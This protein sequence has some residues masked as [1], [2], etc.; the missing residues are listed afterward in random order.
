MSARSHL[1]ELVVEPGRHVHSQKDLAPRMRDALSEVEGAEPM[2]KVVGMVYDRSEILSRHIELSFEELDRRLD[3]YLAVNEATRRL[4]ARALGRLFAGGLSPADC[5]AMVVVTSSHSGFPSLSRLLQQEAG[6]RLDALCYDL[7]GLGCAGPTHGL[8]L[9]S[10]LLE[11]ASVRNV[12]LLCVDVMATH[13]EARRH[14]RA[15][16]MEQLVAHCLASDGAAALVLSKDPGSRSLLSFGSCSLESVLWEDALD[17][18]FF[19]ASDDNQPYLAVGKDIRTRLLQETEA[20]FRQRTPDEP[21]LM[22]PGG[23]AL[24]ARLE[25]AEPGLAPSIGISRSIL[26]EHGNLGAPSLLWVWERAL[27]SGMKMS[28]ALTLFAL[29]PG[30]VTTAIRLEEVH[31]TSEQAVA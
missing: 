14:T 2:K 20:F 12:C 26:S 25:R 15:P 1:L 24:M 7:T 23:A 11:Q 21:F 18:N 22:H 31:Q 28:P 29:G 30:I 13:G 3:W 17:Q 19:S 9:A 5:D 6:F 27:R 16:T 8:H 10:M 4:S